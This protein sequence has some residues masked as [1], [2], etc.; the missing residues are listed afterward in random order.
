MLQSTFSE[1]NLTVVSRKGFC[2]RKP[3]TVIAN[4]LK[5]KKKQIKHWHF[6]SMSFKALAFFAECSEH[7]CSL[8]TAPKFMVLLR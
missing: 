8:I 4:S 2:E 6:L 5:H 3:Y 1:E 7:I